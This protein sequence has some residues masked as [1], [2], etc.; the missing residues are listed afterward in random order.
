MRGSS[1]EAR[2]LAEYEGCVIK[3]L[4]AAVV[5]CLETA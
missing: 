2:L 3:C 4:E 1:L 5:E